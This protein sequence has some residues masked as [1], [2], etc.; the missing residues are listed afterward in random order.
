MAARVQPLT[1]SVLATPARMAFQPTPCCIVP[2]A[3][4]FLG[5]CWRLAGGTADLL[6]SG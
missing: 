3:A 2:A 4:L 5:M 6:P 1:N